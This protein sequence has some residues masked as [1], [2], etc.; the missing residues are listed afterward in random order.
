MSVPSWLQ[1]LRRSEIVEVVKA[2]SAPG[3]ILGVP[4]ER[5]MRALGGGQADFT[6]PFEHLDV[7]DVALLYGYYLQKRHIEELTEAFRQLVQ[8]TELANPV[9]I[10]LGCGPFTGGLAFAAIHGKPFTYV[11]MDRAASM[12]RLGEHLARRAIQTSGI[13][14]EWQWTESLGELVWSRAPGWRPI[15]VI[16]SYL[17]ASPTLDPVALVAELEATMP[18]IGRGPVTVLYTNAI[19]EEKNRAF[20][21]FRAALEGS[22]FSMIT[23]ERGQIPSANRVLELTYALFHRRAQTTLE[24]GAL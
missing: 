16:V 10:D 19:G 6:K 14:I 2:R 5:V 1:D 17:L 13:Q 9:V 20:P 21:A 3:T 23:N 11:G 7:D 12:C 15:I 24:L 18:R 22:G 4:E 8:G